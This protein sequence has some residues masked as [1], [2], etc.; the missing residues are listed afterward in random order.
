MTETEMQ[1][2]APDTSVD[3]EA[4]SS[5]SKPGVVIKFD[6]GQSHHYAPE[7]FLGKTCKE[8]YG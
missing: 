5:P 4:P 1:L 8:Q 2:P 6:S 3:V 7:T